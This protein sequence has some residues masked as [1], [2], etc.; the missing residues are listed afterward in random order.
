MFFV[1]QPIAEDA[2]DALRAQGRVAVGYGDDAVPIDAV[3]A[4][5]T[6]LVVRTAAVT[7]EL[8]DRAPRLRAIVRIGAGVENIDIPAAT[9]AGVAVFST[10]GSNAVSVAEMTVGLALAVARELPRWD[11]AVRLG[12]FA[13]R[14]TDPGITISGKTWGIVGF[15]NVGEAVAR[16][17]GGGLGMRVITHHP[18]RSDD[19]VRARGAEPTVWNALLEQSDVLSIHVPKAPEN[20]GLIGAAEIARMRP[21]AILVDV[22]RGGV[23]ESVALAEALHRGHLRGAGLDVFSPEPPPH[24]HPVIGAPRVVLSPHR[25][26]RTIDAIEAQG[27]L[28]V[29]KLLACLNDGVTVGALNGAAHG[30]R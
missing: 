18:R 8:I 6:G 11:Q 14:E 22:S 26:G 16:I 4:E 3:L 19:H 25:S 7:G 30:V 21:S 9:R 20:L 15:G 27:I 17:A 5:L 2:V 23:V 28:G 13:E 24:D 29:E 12:R 10:A 1:A